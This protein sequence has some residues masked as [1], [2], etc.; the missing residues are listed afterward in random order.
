MNGYKIVMRRALDRRGDTDDEPKDI[1]KAEGS[2]DSEN[3]IIGNL[4]VCEGD[5]VVESVE[6]GP[7]KI[8]RENHDLHRSNLSISYQTYN[9]IFQQILKALPLNKYSGACLI[10]MDITLKYQNSAFFYIRIIKK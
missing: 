10:I 4:F 9:P 2:K 6:D 7:D 3:L 1:G 5:G 8:Q